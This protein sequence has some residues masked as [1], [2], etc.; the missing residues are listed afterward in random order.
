MNKATNYT[1]NALRK[2]YANAFGQLIAKPSCDEDAD[3]ASRK[4]YEAL[5]AEKP[6]MIA[7][8]GGT[9]M[10]CLMNY[11]G[12]HIQQ[13]GV[14]PYIKGQTYPWWWESNILN[15]MQQWSGFFPP[16][17]DKIEQFCELMLTDI[18]EVDILGSWLKHEIF[19]DKELRKAQ[20]VHLRLLEPFWAEN[21]W[22]EA[23]KGKKIL[24]VHPFDNEIEQQYKRKEYLF[25]RN[26]LPYF[27]LK[28][29]KAIQSLMGE[30]TQFI[31]WFEALEYMKTE[32]D[33]EDYDICL[34]GAGAYG[35]HL[36]AHVKRTGKKAIH[37]GGA[38]QLLFG[39]RGRRWED[40]NYGVKEW[41]IPHGSYSCLMNENWIRP[42]ESAKPMGANKVEGACYW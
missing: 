4:I 31:D 12:V 6:C 5:M 7:R 13:N 8:F 11:L 19:F 27:E 3:S 2:I 10:A 15:K 24:V 41:G 22:T 37:L 18:P 42:G 1:L 21:P 29:I 9:E 35:F 32:I 14:I 36:A 16:T 25:K 26:I 33:K 39:I 28:T 23:L 38:L 34:I 17:V 20:K 40:P 30:K